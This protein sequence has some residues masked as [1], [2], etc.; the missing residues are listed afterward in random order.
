MKNQLSKY[1]FLTIICFTL[2]LSNLLADSPLTSTE[3][4]QGYLD[5]PMV[6]KALN[7]KGKITTELIEFIAKE[8]TPL[9][10]KLAIINATGWKIKTTQNAESY[11]KYIV[12]HKKYNSGYSDYMSFKSAASPEEL[13]CYAYLSALDNYFDVSDAYRIAALAQS[14]ASDSYAINM[15]T[16]LIKAQVLTSI[17]ETCQVAMLFK[18]IKTKQE[19]KIDVRKEAQTLMHEYIDDIS[20]NCTL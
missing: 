7:N 11:L 4:Y 20:A 16:A 2:N 10:V 8:D 5:I 1:L 13:I 14:K 12:K 3:F 6:K 19:F 15:I 17:D 9:D 18:T